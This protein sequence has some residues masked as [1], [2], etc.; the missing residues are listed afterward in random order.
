MCSVSLNNVLFKRGFLFFLFFQFCSK[1][2]LGII[3]V[4]WVPAIFILLFNFAI[5]KSFEYMIFCLLRSF[6]PVIIKN[7][8]HSTLLSCTEWSSKGLLGHSCF[9]PKLNGP[10]PYVFDKHISP[11]NKSLSPSC[12]T[13]LTCNFLNDTKKIAFL[14]TVVNEDLVIWC[15]RPQ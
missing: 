2:F 15:L 4:L 3:L 13:S 1:M 8:N 11:L 7:V 12:I 9:V 5:R 14:S 6:F 10:S